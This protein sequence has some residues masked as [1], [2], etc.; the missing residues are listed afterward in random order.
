MVRALGRRCAPR[1]Q[2][3]GLRERGPRAASRP[4]PTRRRPAGRAGGERRIGAAPA[5][6]NEVEREQLVEGAEAVRRR[7]AR[8]SLPR[9]RARTARRRQPRARAA[10]AP[11][12]GSDASSSASDA[13]TAA[14]TATP[15]TYGVVALGGRPRPQSPVLGRPPEL[16]EV[17]GV[18][19]AVAIDR[20]G[21]PGSTSASSASPA[22]RQS[23]SS[24][25]RR[26]EGTA[27]AADSRAGACRGRKPSASRTGA[28]G[29][30]RSRAASSSIDASS[31]QCR[32]S[33]TTTS[34]RSRASS[35]SSPRDGPVGAVALVGDGSRLAVAARAA[36]RDDPA[37]L[38]HELGAPVLVEVEL[39]GRDVGVERVDPDAERHVALELRRRAREHEEA[40]LLRR[41]RTLSEQVCLADA[42]LALHR[43]ARRRRRSEGPSSAAS[44]CSSSDSR[45]TVGDAVFD[46]T[47]LRPYSRVSELRFRESSPMIS[48]LGQGKLTPCRSSFFIT[49]TPPA[50]CAAAFA[51]WTG[52]RSPLRH[53]QQRRR[54][55]AGG[56]ALWWRVQADDSAEA[57]SLLPPFLARRTTPIEVRDVEIP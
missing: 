45:P 26:A 56:H 12:A 44:S 42:R 29:S 43:D 23:G 39:L 35:S 34:G 3:V 24:A 53:G 30:R 20:R 25:I 21:A 31:P 36:T 2:C 4:V 50:E 28:S 7:R 1:G 6:A 14:G 48:R 46:S 9:D 37:Q 11:S 32:S 13:A 51:A 49:D 41:L 33:S 22:P 18:A 10:P 54:C 52:F 47:P 5:S 17:E 27:S 19:A 16:L 40:L 15:A 38:V 55:L 8:R 57:L